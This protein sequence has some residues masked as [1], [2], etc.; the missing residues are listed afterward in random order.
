MFATAP[1]E[2]RLNLEV[3]HYSKDR[4]GYSIAGKVCTRSTWNKGSSNGVQ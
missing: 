4:V 1:I 2:E 3:E